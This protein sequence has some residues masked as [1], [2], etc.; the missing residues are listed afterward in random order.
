MEISD[1]LA[2]TA[3]CRRLVFAYVFY[4][5]H[6]DGAGLEALFAQDASL[7]RGELKL[8]GC[9]QIRQALSQRDPL[10]QTH[11]HCS[12]VHI[13]VHSPEQAS[14]VTYFQLFRYRGAATDGPS[15]P[16]VPTSAEV[17]GEY[18]DEF[19]KTPEGWRFQTR[20]TRAAFR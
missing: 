19:V 6:G 17:V 16:A 8:K 15:K 13:D 14:G 20:V 9:A 1:K 4:V 10:L 7:E 18:H 12:T 5:D 11:H 2:I 3:E